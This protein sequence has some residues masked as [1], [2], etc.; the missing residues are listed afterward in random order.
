MMSNDETLNEVPSAAPQQHP[1]FRFSKPTLTII[2]HFSDIN[3]SLMFHPGSELR[4]ISQNHDLMAVAQIAET[5]PRQFGIYNLR[6]MLAKIATM[7]DPL[8]VACD[9]RLELRDDETSSQSFISYSRLILEPPGED[10]EGQRI[11]SFALPSSAFKRLMKIMSI[12]GDDIHHEV[13]FVRQ[14]N[15]LTLEGW[16]GGEHRGHQMVLADAGG[17]D[18]AAR[19]NFDMFS[20]M[21]P[22]D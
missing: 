10:F 13:R 5:I 12:D 14:T 9:D 20:Q 22:L 16:L 1:A 18:F 6:K 11:T 2:R 8:V 4:T 15:V 3:P 19:I 7:G 21:L 17:I